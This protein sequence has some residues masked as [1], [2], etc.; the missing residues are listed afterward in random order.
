[1]LFRILEQSFGTSV[2]L[3]ASALL[4]GFAHGINPGATL[5]SD[6]A[7]VIEAGLLLG[8]AYALTRNLWLAI[9]IHTGWNFTEGSVFGA[10]VSGTQGHGS[11]F[12][13]TLTG[14]DLLS[15]GAFGP[16]ASVI[17][18]AVCGSAALILGVLVYRRGGW[19][20]PAFRLSLG[21]GPEESIPLS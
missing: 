5:I 13:S 21:D 3:V 7:I 18:I 20:R 8:V 14:S 9:G 1:V 15:G 11:L 16:E 4:F 6:V 2:A 10:S 19:L 17:A 12:H